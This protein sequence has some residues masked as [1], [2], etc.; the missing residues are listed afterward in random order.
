MQDLMFLTD[1]MKHLQ[2]LNLELQG[3]E[4][5][6]SDLAQTVISFQNKTKVFE[7]DITSKT[8]RYSYLVRQSSVTE[9][10]AAE[11]ELTELQEDLA[12]K[13]F[14][15]C[16]FT[17]EFWQQVMERKYPKLKNTSARLLLFLALHIAVNL[18][19]L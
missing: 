9:V 8:F 17:V 13:N 11:M 4:K 12:L 18:Y 15:K 14:N 10:S 6:I 3:T 19:S 5:I 16:H 7:R 1:I 2:I